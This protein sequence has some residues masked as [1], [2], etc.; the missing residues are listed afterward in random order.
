MGQRVNSTIAS[1]A[2]TSATGTQQHSSRAGT[3]GH[4]TAVA[5]QTSHSSGTAVPSR[6]STLS[7][8]DLLR[9]LGKAASDLHVL[10]TSRGV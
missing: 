3:A 1:N 5:T 4:Q 10:L 2:P 6:L 9:T 7:D 8:D